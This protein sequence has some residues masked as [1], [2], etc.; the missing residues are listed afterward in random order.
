MEP[1][2]L[3]ARAEL[4]FTTAPRPQIGGVSPDGLSCRTPAKR[5]VPVLPVRVLPVRVL[6][7]C[8]RG[9]G[10]QRRG[11]APR[12][13]QCPAKESVSKRVFT[14]LYSGALRGRTSVSLS[15]LI[16][17]RLFL[18]LMVSDKQPSPEDMSE[19]CWLL[20]QRGK[21]SLSPSVACAL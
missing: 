4:R 7:V 9:A 18:R 16:A 13:M 15:L 12:I 3:S 14:S 6:P 10:R 20:V 5:R 11:R 17:L 21:H 1:E 8:R 2:P 19:R